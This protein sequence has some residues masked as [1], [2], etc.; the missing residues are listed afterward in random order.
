MPPR[1]GYRIVPK[2]TG[3][4]KLLSFVCRVEAAGAAEHQPAVMPELVRDMQGRATNADGDMLRELARCLD[5]GWAG[6]NDWW[7]P[8]AWRV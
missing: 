7:D 3:G 8:R 5:P 6:V 1:R 4:F 2:A